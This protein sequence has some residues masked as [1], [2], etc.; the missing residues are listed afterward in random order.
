MFIWKLL[1]MTVFE[2]S[3]MWKVSHSVSIFK[4]CHNFLFEYICYISWTKIKFTLLLL[5]TFFFFNFYLCTSTIQNFIN[6]NLQF[7]W[8]TQISNSTHF[9]CKCKQL[10][11]L[12]SV[13]FKIKNYVYIYRW[14]WVSVWDSNATGCWNIILPISKASRWPCP[15]SGS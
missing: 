9:G 13:I 15:S 14:K 12:L 4:K 3:N 6:I 2:C 8:W 10:N 5:V 1:T 7:Q 11:F